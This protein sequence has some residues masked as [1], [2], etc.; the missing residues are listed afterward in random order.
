MLIEE[1]EGR[2]TI[3]EYRGA[4]QA[5]VAVNKVEF[6]FLLNPVCVYADKTFRICEIDID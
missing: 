3:V 6:V 1:H 2:G 5:C 4:N